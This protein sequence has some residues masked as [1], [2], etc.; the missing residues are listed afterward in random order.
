V[1][2]QHG[3]NFQEMLNAQTEDGQYQILAKLLRADRLTTAAVPI[4]FP[5]AAHGAARED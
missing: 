4:T 3:D 1:A 2:K 5:L